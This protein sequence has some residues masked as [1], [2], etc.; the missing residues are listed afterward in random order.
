MDSGLLLCGRSAWTVEAEHKDGTN[1]S[2]IDGWWSLQALQSVANEALVAAFLLLIRLL[3]PAADYTQRIALPSAPS[4]H[5]PH[6][7]AGRP[8]Q[9]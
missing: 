8:S 7:H 4:S 9:P 2:E 1:Q 6:Y 5:S 3:L